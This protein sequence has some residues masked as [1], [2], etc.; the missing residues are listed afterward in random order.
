MAD[1]NVIF[2][3]ISMQEAV[4]GA[5]VL[6]VTVQP[7]PI[8]ITK[9]DKR[10]GDGAYMVRKRMKPRWVKITVEL[11]MNARTGA[12]AEAVRRLTVWA[13]S[14]QEKPLQLG[15]YPFK[16]LCCML[17]SVSNVS[18]GS[19]Y[20]P[21]ELVF[22]AYQEPFFV[23]Q[24]DQRAAVGEIVSVM[25]DRPVSPAITHIITKPL[26]N[27]VWVLS[28]VCHISLIGQYDSG[29]IEIDVQKGLVTLDG[30]SIMHSLDLSSRF[31]MLP[32]GRH[33]TVG[34]EGGTITWR[35]RWRN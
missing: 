12:Y 19:W 27:P 31:D 1:Y 7:A 20:K 9:T 2:D 35:E 22:T 28:E 26:T 13:E 32:P 4:P 24:F 11:P 16:E 5:Q 3:G 18:L 23:D 10:C 30:I 25:G 29:I 15:D 14:E 8:E 6:D 33:V 17:S 21:I 34:P